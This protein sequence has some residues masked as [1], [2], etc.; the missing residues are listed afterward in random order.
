MSSNFNTW[1]RTS[2]TLKLVIIG[3]LVLVLLIPTNM[4]QNLIQERE[5]T[6]DSAVSE[7]ASKW[8][9]DQTIGTPIISIPYYTVVVNANNQKE[10]YRNYAHILPD[11]IKIKTKL[12]P[13]T[14]KRGLYEVVLYNTQVSILGSF[15]SEIQNLQQKTSNTLRLDQACIQLGIS[16]LK[17]LK[18]VVQF[19][20]DGT[21]TFEFNPG[22]PNTDIYNSGMSF[23][24]D[25]TAKDAFAFSCNLNLNGSTSLHFQPYGKK[26]MV[27]LTTTWANPSYQGA[28]LPDTSIT[29]ET[30]SYAR[31]KI[32]QLNRNYPQYGFG[33]FIRQSERA[34]ANIT[35]GQASSFGLRLILP[36][37][38]YQKITRSAKYSIMFIL[39]T[40]VAFFFV[41]IINKKKIHPIQYLLIGFGIVLFYVLLLSISE[42]TNFE[43]A[44]WISCAGIVL[45]ISLYTQSM[46][47]KIKV[48]LLIAAILSTLYVFFYALLQLQDFSLLMGSIGL[49]II[50]A[51]TMYLTRNIDWYKEDNSST[52]NFSAAPESLD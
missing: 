16:D 7:V 17:G 24:I 15:K 51:V 22:V 5:T 6:R 12:V 28:F 34:A 14:K 43:T 52:E 1:A 30:G 20:M 40:V 44:Y 18:D 9:M 45:L 2:I 8:G 33:D 47:R 23:P 25:L 19:N 37:D 36:V 50:L 49:F 26:T 39:L 3:I 48:T 35:D 13:S 31:W 42:H 46:L 27:E 32:L 10:T 21:D 29:T 41:E 38:Q 11:D 4:V